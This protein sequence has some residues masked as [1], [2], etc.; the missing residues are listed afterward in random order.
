MEDQDAE[1]IFTWYSDLESQLVEF[2]NYVPYSDENKDTQ[3]PRLANQIVEAGSLLDT[4]FR[5]VSQEDKNPRDLSIYDYAPEYDSRLNLSEKNTLLY[6][7]PPRVL[8]PFEGWVSSD[9]GGYNQVE[10]WKSHNR[11]K[12]NRTDK[13]EL[14][15]LKTAVSILCALHQVIASLPVFLATLFR[16]DAVSSN[17]DPDA[18]I[19]EIRESG[20]DSAVIGLV[21]TELFATPLPPRRF[22]E[23]AEQIGGSL[24][25]RRL[26]RF[27]AGK[28]SF[29]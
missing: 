27:L 7:Y 5:K 19:S 11:L 14:A 15:T 24:V 8:C 29:D 9:T 10:W 22:P 17:Y 18:A 23:Q 13:V 3:L 12:H 2:L 16:N 1:H 25:S 28:R 4:V 21:E 26:N 20:D 6:K